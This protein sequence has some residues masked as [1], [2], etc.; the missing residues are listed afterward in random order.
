MNS[1]IIAGGHIDL[2]F[3]KKVLESRAWDQVIA[4]D[5]GICFCAETGFTPDMILGD[6]D[7]ADPEDLRRYRETVPG[8]ILTFP[9]RKDE[10]DTELAMDCAISAGMDSITILGGTG[11]RMDHVLGN[12]QLL[13]R[14]MEAGVTC[15]LLDQ[16]N[17][18]RLIREKLTL[19]RDEQFGSYVSLIPFTPAVEGLTLTGFAYNV[20]NFTLHS[21]SSRGI[22]NEIADQRAQI[23]M[24]R[25]ILTVIESRD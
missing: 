12:I 18:I 14:A 8:S 25:G 10:T 5:A 16:N 6:F 20:E 17:R 4:A 19:Y 24:T 1:L 9:A 2:P 23:S 15:F 3:A 11:S 22:S 7:S 13:A 21:G